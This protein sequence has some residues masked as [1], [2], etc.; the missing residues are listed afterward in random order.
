MPALHVGV[1]VNPEREPGD[2]L[3]VA[4][5]DVRPRP[6]SGLGESVDGVAAIQSTAERE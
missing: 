1:G 5:L 3:G 6:L 4:W 2:E